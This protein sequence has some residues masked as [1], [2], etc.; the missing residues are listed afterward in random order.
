MIHAPVVLQTVD[1]RWIVAGR[2]QETDLPKGSFVSVGEQQD[3]AG[4]HTSVWEID[5]TRVRHLLT[6]PSGRDC[7]YCGLAM[8][9]DGETILMSYY[10][11]HARLPLPPGPPTPSDVYLAQ[12]TL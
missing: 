5:S 2:S 9:L 7:S 10:S 12:M 4:H 6:L 11:Q 1:K 3:P 8:A